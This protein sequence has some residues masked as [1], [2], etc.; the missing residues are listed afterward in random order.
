[1]SE[2]EKSYSRFCHSEFNEESTLVSVIAMY[3]AIQSLKGF[4]LEVLARFFVFS[5]F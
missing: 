3:E 2:M 1:M 5:D 4:H